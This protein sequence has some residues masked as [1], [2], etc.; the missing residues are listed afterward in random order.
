MKAKKLATA[1]IPETLPSLET[2]YTEETSM[3]EVSP[4]K[5]TTIQQTARTAERFQQTGTESA[6]SSVT[7]TLI[8]AKTWVPLQTRASSK[9]GTLLMSE[10]LLAQV[11]LNTVST[12]AQSRAEL[13]EALPEKAAARKTLTKV[14]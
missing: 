10:A 13:R 14:P 11:M 8:S 6:E 5:L 12:K 2:I 9:G 4:E 1:L 3:S 7:A